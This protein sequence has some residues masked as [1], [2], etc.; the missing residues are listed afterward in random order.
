[1]MTRL[2]DRLVLGAFARLFDIAVFVLR[3]VRRSGA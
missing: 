3:R 2:T 1:M